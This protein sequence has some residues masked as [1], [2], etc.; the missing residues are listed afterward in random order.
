MNPAIAVK[1][2]HPASPPQ[3]QTK[4]KHF[5]AKTPEKDSHRIAPPFQPTQKAM[6]LLI[7]IAADVNPRVPTVLFANA[8]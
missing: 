6:T 4:A 5:I 2:Q 3:T 1:H 7:V 8:Q